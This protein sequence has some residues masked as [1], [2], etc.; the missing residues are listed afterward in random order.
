MQRCILSNLQPSLS[1]WWLTGFVDAE[2]CFRISI[3]KNKELKTGWKV[4][5]CFK[6]SLHKRDKAVLEQ[7]QS[8]LGV[9][10]IYTAGITAVSLEVHTFKELEVIIAHFFFEKKNIR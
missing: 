1:V 2:G 7:I 3:L 10:K 4:G 5:A 8:F 6:I 9:G